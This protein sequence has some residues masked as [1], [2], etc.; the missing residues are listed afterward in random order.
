MEESFMQKIEE[1]REEI[2]YLRQKVET[3]QLDNYD[4]TLVLLQSELAVR[5]K[6]YDELDEKYIQSMNHRDVLM[7]EQS[8]FES[9]KKQLVVD[10]H[11][12]LKELHDLCTMLR[13]ENKFLR[14]QQKVGKSKIEIPKNEIEEKENEKENDIDIPLN[15]INENLEH[16]F[17]HNET[18]FSDNV[19]TYEI[20][21]EHLNEN[22]NED[23]MKKEIEG[24]EIFDEVTQNEKYNNLPL[25]EDDVEM[26]FLSQNE[27][28]M[29]GSKRESKRFSQ[30]NTPKGTPKKR[31]SQLLLTEK[32][33]VEMQQ[34]NEPKEVKQI[35]SKILGKSINETITDQFEYKP[36]E[37]M[38][39]KLIM[40]NEFEKYSMPSSYSPTENL[41]LQQPDF[42]EQQELEHKEMVD[43][44][45]KEIQ[46][47]KQQNEEL[48]KE[49]DEIKKQ[50]NE[51]EKKSKEM[52]SLMERNVDDKSKVIETLQQII[53]NLE[54][55][56]KHSQN[57]QKLL[58]E[59]LENYSKASTQEVEE[60]SRYL[61]LN[62]ICVVLKMANPQFNSC[63]TPVQRIHE[64]LEQDGIPMCQWPIGVQSLL[65]GAINGI[66]I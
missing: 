42:L 60:N 46:E 63:K 21:K 54:E 19:F 10:Y 23:E 36:M 24:E 27:N 49:K 1:L 26:L 8:L 3:I 15:V 33:L 35:G 62:S 7:K 52:N 66:P 11:A 34:Q 37:I 53:V 14:K 4:C 40:E 16:D 28:Q 39:P 51:I 65:E 5:T 30:R 12:K 32:D 20:P 44:L 58:E 64:R 48:Q 6:L 47:L 31:Q 55:D 38:E 22:Q 25:A 2:L 45:N 41:Y 56:L 9:R 43:K 17:T 29:K 59:K 57:K 61:L 13:T 18:D 50:M